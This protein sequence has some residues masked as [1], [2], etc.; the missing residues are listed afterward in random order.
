[1][2]NYKVLKGDNFRLAAGDKIGFGV[3]VFLQTDESN[4]IYELCKVVAHEEDHV[5]CQA[6]FGT[7]L[8]VKLTFAVHIFFIFLSFPLTR[9]TGL[10]QIEEYLRS[11]KNPSFMKKQMKKWY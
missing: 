10:T 9:F 11:W 8:H 4:A 3:P 6:Y 1:M 5:S 2:N 7:A